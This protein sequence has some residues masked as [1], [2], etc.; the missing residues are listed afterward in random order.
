M[1]IK[2]QNNDFLLKKQQDFY[3][4]AIMAKKKDAYC[5]LIM[6]SV[7]FGPTKAEPTDLQ[8]AP[9]DHSGNSPTLE[10]PVGLGPTTPRLQI[11]CST[12]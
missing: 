6:G 8:S 11:T 9:F 10:L 12:N 7:G 3:L 5:I 1:L 2:Y 4:I